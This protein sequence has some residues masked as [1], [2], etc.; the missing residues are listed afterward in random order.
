[1]KSAK[2]KDTYPS[3]A[4]GARRP[5]GPG[6]AYDGKEDTMPEDL[7]FDE[8]LAIKRLMGFLAVEGVTG[9]EQ[10]IGQEVVRTL[11]DAGV[12]R[13]W[14]RFD[15]AHKQIPLP[16]QTGNL[17]V[18]L[19]GTR[20]GPR[21]LFMTHLDTVPL[22]AG[23]EPVR[24]GERI[25]AAGRTALGGDNRTGVGTLVTMATTLL[26][27]KL[28][29]GPLTLLFTVREESGLW[30][31]RF[32]EPADLGN[33]VLGFNVDGSSARQI[34]VGAVGADRW[35]VEITGK[36][37]HAGAYPE[38]GVS[39]TVVASL[40]LAEVYR[41]GWFGKV[42][43]DGK[44]GTS[45]VGVFG[46]KDGTPAGDATNVVTDYVLIRG[47]SRSHNLRFI[48]Q[49]TTAYR[50]AFRSAGKQVTNE[51]GRGAKVAFR[52]RRDYYPF[53]LKPES[54]VVRYALAASRRAGWEAALRITNGGLDANW[55]TRRGI[56][57]ITFGA[58]QNNVHTIEEFVDLSEYRAGC[59]LALA[60]A[61]QDATE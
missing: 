30:G 10:A 23:A 41:N 48:G 55:T 8:D 2:D 42:R 28:P 27:R 40:A 38:K 60:L 16:T 53:R 33:P 52:A 15:D 44:E 18:T 50:N 34:T 5:G 59:R 21:R 49:I 56:P 3:P 54:P 17:I 22:C 9:Q 26:E 46:G 6:G 58:G 25:V 12:P 7:V 24:K 57:T 31:A 29:H 11:L 45:N 1:M 20:P 19:P 4:A 61:M 47:E 35:E 43:R 39:A 51:R 36:A 32:V 13:K 37:A 14:V